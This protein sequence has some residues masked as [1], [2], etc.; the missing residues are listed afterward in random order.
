MNFIVF[1][2]ALKYI[3]AYIVMVLETSCFLFSFVFDRLMKRNVQLSKIATASFLV[4]FGILLSYGTLENNDSLVI[5]S[6]FAIC[7]SLTLGLFNS[8]LY[9]ISD[10][11]DKNLLIMLPILILC[12]PMGVYEITQS[13][14]SLS[15]V[16]L[17]VVV[18][19]FIQAGLPVYFLT[20]AASHFSGTTLS[21]FFLLTLPGTFLVEWLF[22]GVNSDSL[23][24]A[25]S[26]L[27]VSSV[28]IN[29]YMTRNTG[30]SSRKRV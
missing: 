28:V 9:L 3:D 23:I 18:L 2:Y 4:G 6:I 30:E 11:K 13:D 5:G 26:L 24:I 27:I 10:E 21:I 7:A 12:L 17:I 19:G 22:M 25:A 1:S 15:N 29:V 16:V 8:T 20:K 14:T